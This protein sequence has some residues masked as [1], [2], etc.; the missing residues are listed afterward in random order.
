MSLVDW[1]QGNVEPAPAPKP[2]KPQ[3]Q[4]LTDWYEGNTTAPATPQAAPAAQPQELPEGAKSFDPYGNPYFGEGISGI[5][6][7]W[8]YNYT[9]DVKPVNDLDWDDLRERWKSN[10][11]KYH[12]YQKSLNQGGKTSPTA[13]L[14]ATKGVLGM[15]AEAAGKAWQEA[16]AQGSLLS[17]I[18]K[19][20]SASVTAI[21]E[22]FSIPSQKL[23]QG[24]GAANAFRE[25]AGELE[26]PLPKLDG[27]GQALVY[28]MPIAGLAYDFTR[29]A[30]SPQE[31]KWDKVGK[32]IE[33]GWQSGRIFYS[34]L[35]DSTLK[36]KFLQE[37]REGKD[38]ALIAMK[39]QNPLAELGGQFV[40]D[41]FN[42]VGA[43]AKASKTAKELDAAVEAVTESGILKSVA[44]KNAFKAIQEATDNTS[45]VRALDDLSKAQ[46]EV[47]TGITKNSKLLNVGFSAD[48]LTTTS[49]QNAIVTKGKQLMG[50]MALVL[51]EQGLSYDGIAEG[52]LSGIRSVSSNADEMRKGLAGLSKL[53]NANMWLAD[54]YVE[55]FVVLNR[56]MTNANG[57][58]DGNKLRNLTK[59][60][61]PTQFAE[62]ATRLYLSAAKGEFK[63]V[64]QMAE[65]ANLAKQ[66]DRSGGIV[67]DETRALAEQYRQLPNHV[68]IL[69]KVNNAL[70][71]AT[72]PINRVLF[73]AYFNLQGG[74]AVRNVISNNELIFLDKGAGAWFKDGKYWSTENISG[75]LTDLYGTLPESAHG[76]KSLVSSMTDRPAWG[77]GKLMEWGEENAAMRIVGASVRDTFKK[78]LPKAMPDLAKHIEAGTLTE[79]QSKKLL[80]L[81]EKNNLNVAKAIEEF[82]DFYKV[83]SVEDWRNLDFVSDFEKEAL[84]GLDF[85]GD[86]E[87][88][89][90]RGA[91]SQDDVEA[92]FTK[93]KN[94]IDE[95]AKLAT[96]DLP[97]LSP[98]HPGVESWGDLAKAAEEGHLD[99][100][101]QQVFTA[102]MESAEQARMEYQTLLDDVALKAQ[103]ALNLEGN[104][105]GAMKLGQEMNRIRDVLRRSAPATSK[106]AYET[107]QDAWRWS[108]E[109]K[110]LKKPDAKELASY[111]TRAGLE[112][113]TP[114]DLDKKSLL[115][116]IWENRFQK[117]SELWNGALDAVVGE[118]ETVL[119]QMG[120]VIDTTEV[121]SMAT[122]ARYITQKAQAY[123]QAV[124]QN[125]ALKIMPARDVEFVA[126]Q[127][128]VTTDEIL[129]AI[130]NK[131]LGEPDK[132]FRWM[133]S[134]TE[135]WL[136]ATVNGVKHAIDP[137]GK[138][139][140]FEGGAKKLVQKFESVDKAKK[141]LRPKG[142]IESADKYKDLSDI[143]T[144]EIMNV[145][146][147]ARQEKG[148]STT[149][150]RAAETAA[151]T[152]K[153]SLSSATKT[154]VHELPP[155]VQERFEQI[156]KQLL[157]ELSSGQAGKRVTVEG[158]EGGAKTTEWKGISSTNAEWYKKLY[159]SGVKSKKVV[160]SALNKI[161]EDGGK[162]KGVNV[163]RMKELI[164]ER[165]AF[166]DEATGTPPDLYALQQLGADQKKMQQAL[167]NWN[168]I[169]KQEMTLEEAIQ[170]TTPAEE[171][172]HAADQP[173]FD[174][175][176]NLVEPQG[177]EIPPPHPTGTEPSAP[178]AWNENAKGAKYV[179]DNIK[180]QIIERWGKTNPERVPSKQMDSVLDEVSK[181]LE[182]RVG[183]MKAIALRIAKK[184]R[185]FTLLDY[186]EKTYGDMAKA[187]ILPFHF[188]YSRSYK[189]WPHRI[190]QNPQIVSH[191]AAYKEYL[192]AENKDLPDWYKHQLNIN[193]F[194]DNP[195]MAGKSFL[196][197]PADHPLYVNLEATFN[198]LYGLTGTDYNDPVKRNN[199]AT[200]TIDDLGK[201]GPT[202]YAPI[203]LGIAAML[204]RDGETD[205]AARWAGRLF[206]ETTQIKALSSTLLGRPVEL[207][208]AVNFFSGGIDTQ[209]R[210]RMSY[211]A[212]QLI[213][214]EQFTPEQ[215]MMDF[216]KQ[217]GAAWDTAY[218]M[219][220]QSRAAS[221]FTSYF[222][223]VGFK[224]RSTN[225][226]QV[227][228]MYGDLNKLY[229]MS[230]MMDPEKY[231]MAWEQLRS[232]YP[233][234]FV[235]TVL[236]SR[237]GGDKRDAAL[238]YEVLNR[239]PPGN[240]S[241]ALATI[242][243]SHDE[244]DKFYKSKGFADPKAKF[245]KQEKDRFM[246]AVI[247]LAAMLKIPSAA[248]RQE[249]TE[250]RT[251]Y[252]QVY[253]DIE[254]ELGKDIWDKVSLYY[255]LK[256]DNREK[257]QQYSM[258]HPEIFQAMQMKR[259]AV[260]GT[261]I[262]GAYYGSIETVEVYLDGKIR[263]ELSNKYGPNIYEIQSGYYAAANPRGY[264]AQHPELK[265]FWNEKRALEAQY[266][267]MFYQFASQL[268]EGKGAEFQEGFA[269][270]SYTQ[271]QLYGALQPEE[272]IPSW[273]EVS[274]GMPEWL[275]NEIANYAQTGA[276]LSKRGKK[277][278]AYLAKAG[279]YYDDQSLLRMAVLSMQEPL[280]QPNT[281]QPTLTDWYNK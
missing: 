259:E 56:M 4:P 14:E 70:H 249:W 33:E 251:T 155:T 7:K 66:A 129:Q 15:G 176:G 46:T 83:G 128:G 20:T 217:E 19:A 137:D 198:P 161:I 91:A 220:T 41:P 212:A 213:Q 68:K 85:W 147:Q 24:L 72:D 63:E 102:I 136:E 276:S 118:S 209:E 98:D 221:A 240:M 263:Q 227:E 13:T 90:H 40:L 117:V 257:S 194:A 146:R 11:D 131:G 253:K 79:R 28:G 69:D 32:A 199:W 139:Y 77:F 21:G 58:V 160:E 127:Y 274:T 206:P 125:G 158:M 234:G 107:T 133:P 45:A 151:K 157:D 201:F 235:D 229:A 231:R 142:I 174:E 180:N 230:D 35:F 216:Q 6:K 80:S 242:G 222:L 192:E 23:E 269:P 75:Y 193:P 93:L 18:L 226:I 208:P 204:F 100:D 54:D 270:Q 8:H 148:L 71:K 5:L 275:Q 207:D 44:G 225:D 190:A 163:E 281:G 184:Q 73:P 81:V 169:T 76:F 278:L 200:A 88:L 31:D 57:V 188:F 228:Q 42:L 177:I 59:I 172:L 267:P 185:D 196:G 187:H 29:I 248:T 265:Q 115:K 61:N 1:Y 27:L 280:A 26:S 3:A 152:P 108:D 48:S 268:P 219:A 255:D 94:V 197:I 173:Y 224:P 134:K 171:L 86:V 150:G 116:A 110:A 260:L 165:L 258:L 153:V 101:Q 84:K 279:G 264:L 92:V 191:Y 159:E 37:Y 135:G 143:P 179:L 205:V 25:A 39:L 96:K 277:E 60:K 178:R 82:R 189:N 9:K 113:Q 252:S 99:P 38:P 122:N 10:I 215:I 247:D 162:D 121:Q 130:N 16:E 256:D 211:A 246:S 210:G 49:R 239:I 120:G 182:P 30:L 237:K 166:G 156:A 266:E 43:F 78:M 183:E 140:K 64:S 47:V 170:S 22:L 103:Q 55:S 186:S 202:M 105:P 106:A 233:D 114:L 238:A 218:Q 214:S 154:P 119:K 149:V 50:N 272:K 95:R 12:Q 223:G 126:K 89:A 132:N 236:L 123:R 261:P 74:V 232:K 53:P 141:Y 167:D 175:M 250:A 168:D 51:K 65:A 67:S 195:D 52:I 145:I 273:E 262:L 87:D 138:L 254:E 181:T 244:I 241:E 36:E 109:I 144:D 245:T 2:P 34:S 97:G 203:Q 111:W 124:F 62:E 17:P 104:A 271:E 112:G 243:L 164:I